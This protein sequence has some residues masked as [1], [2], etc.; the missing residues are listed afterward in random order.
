MLFG[1]W[2]QGLLFLAP[3]M[4]P[5]CAWGSV[6]LI[7]TDKDATPGAATVARGS[8]F[9][10]SVMMKS[11]TTGTNDQVTGVDY[12]LQSSTSGIL[13]IASR[14]T[15]ASSGT[16]FPN[17]WQPDSDVVNP[18]LYDPGLNPTNGTDLG[19]RIANLN[20]P[21][22]GNTFEVADFVVSVSASALPGTY[23]ITT[24]SNPGTGYEGPG[25]PN[26]GL[27]F[28]D[29][30]FS[31]QGSFLLTVQLPEPTTVWVIAAG[32]L[33]LRRRAS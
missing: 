8:T 26:T 16:A 12:F 9:A 25:D 17:P 22:S 6:S 4:F 19:G 7:L 27:G 11:T 31:S 28:A 30:P 21:I 32:A 18:S 24:F 15:G 2:R 20:V 10:V 33:A 13:S 5:L 1:S 29:T 14:N 23:T 3:L